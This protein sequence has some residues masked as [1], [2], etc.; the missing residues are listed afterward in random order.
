MTYNSVSDIFAAIEETRGRL[1]ARAEGLSEEQDSFRA[2]P[3]T[4]C[5]R[6][7]IEHLA[8]LE[9]RLSRMMAL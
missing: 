9:E 3:G 2:A 4:W 7:I 6:E 5:A 8:I 1:Y